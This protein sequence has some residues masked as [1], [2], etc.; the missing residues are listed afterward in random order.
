MSAVPKDGEAVSLSKGGCPRGNVHVD[1]GGTEEF[2][3]VASV[4][5]SISR[6]IL[7]VMQMGTFQSRP[8]VPRWAAWGLS[9]LYECLGPLVWWRAP[10]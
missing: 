3:C 1:V 6:G 10:A 2:D 7:Y 9:N 8:A 5:R 4:M